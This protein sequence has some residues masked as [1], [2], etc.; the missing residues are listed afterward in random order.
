MASEIHYL[1]IRHHGPGS[2]RQLV[3]ALE[4]L[5]PDSILIEGAADQSDLI[6]FLGNSQMKPPVALLSFPKDD[7]QEVR[8]WPFA[9]FSPEYQA[10]RWALK[11]KK[12][13]RFIDLPS[14]WKEAESEESEDTSEKKE[15]N[16]VESN[17]R[18]RDPI[19][20][21]AKI[22]GYEDGESWWNEIL[23]ENP[24][25]G[26]V[27]EAIATAMEALR[28]GETAE[29]LSPR[30]IAREAHMRIEIHKEKKNTEGVIVVVCGAYHVPA[31]KKKYAL[32]DDKTAIKSASKQKI[33]ATWAPWTSPRLAMASGYGA[34]VMAPRWY[35]H[36]WRSTRETVISSWLVQV[37]RTLRENDYFV[38]SA[39]VIEAERLATT[40]AVIRNKATPG[41][42]E[43]SEASIAC[44]CFGES[45][46]WQVVETKLLIGSEV[47]EIPD[48]VPLSPLMEDLTRQQKKARLK[49]EAL[50]RELSIDLRS[51]AGLFRST[52]LHQLRILG[53]H[54]GQQLDAGRSRGTFRENWRLTWQPEYAIEL[55]ENLIYG[56]TIEQAATACLVEKLQ[57]TQSL[58]QLG[59]LI[60]DALTAQL[61]EAAEQGIQYLQEHAA[62]SSDCRSLLQTLAPLS[63]I[64]RYGE[65]RAIDTEQLANLFSQISVQGSL[66]LPY[67]SH[68]L[69]KEAALG[70]KQ[71]MLEADSALNLIYTDE[72]EEIATWHEALS[73]LLT[74]DKA[75]RLLV[76]LALRI[77]YEAAYLPSEK[78]VNFIQR[79]LS[80]GTKVIEAADF[81]EGFFEGIGTRLI[82]DENLR[83]AVDTWLTFLEEE[84]FR[85]VTIDEIRF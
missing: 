12:A 72:N 4:Q 47:G 85:G 51:D 26:P 49:P 58:P 55:I 78:I 32:K 54:W 84:L 44:L 76:G 52:L 30:E 53:I 25:P 70:M 83:Q 7:P 66:A 50:S 20:E 24:E 14:Y 57:N 37:A 6:P 45:A 82:Y 61:S 9:E 80:P 60:M 42:E 19:G 11:Y 35:Q 38:S 43:L 34:G 33:L 48:T 1:G 17:R 59:E 81:F 10:I 75:T 18:Y 15:E 31:L 39:S 13:V 40:L 69:D 77:L 23:E 62:Q 16:P 36:L 74:E 79:Q 41:Y 2:S 22:A 21:L 71:T 8:F 64:L 29:D 68:Q 3:K 46:L 28:E 73:K 65:A 67:A 27:F 5:Q 63:N 56:S